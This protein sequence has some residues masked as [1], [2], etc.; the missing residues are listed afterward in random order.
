MRIFTFLLLLSFL[1]S[2]W[3]WRV[4][5]PPDPVPIGPFNATKVWGSKPIYG[6]DTA[7][8]KINYVS[9]A[10]PVLLPGN[11]YVKG[12]YIFQVELGKGMHIIDNTVPSAAHRIGFIT[13][14]GCSQ[15]SIKGTNLYSNSYD[16]LVVIDISDHTN[17]KE[18]SRVKGAFPENRNSYIYIRPLEPGYYEC[19]RYDSV[20]V[21]WRKDSVTTMCYKN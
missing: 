1:S 18:I 12:N 10:Q 4:E 19:P 11:I 16:D 14:N 6:V 20:V 3:K 21:G 8:K 5:L 2:C 17:L 15:I 9:S 7:A 13:I